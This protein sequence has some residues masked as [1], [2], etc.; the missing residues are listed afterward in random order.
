[1]LI[2][3][4]YSLLQPERLAL[5]AMRTV[6]CV[7]CMSAAC[8]VASALLFWKRMSPLQLWLRR[9]VLLLVTICTSWLCQWLI[10]GASFAARLHNLPKTTL[11]MILCCVPLYLLGDWLDRRRIARINAELAKMQGREE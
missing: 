10:Y 7:V 3:L 11:I 8:A 1:M 5:Y 2:L 6:G 4:V 9:G